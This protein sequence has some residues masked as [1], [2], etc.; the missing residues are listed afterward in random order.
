MKK[1]LL[2]LALIAMASFLFVGCLGEGTVADTDTDTDTDTDVVEPCVITYEA[3]K[4]FTDTAGIKYVQGGANAVEV[5]FTTAIAADDSVW[6][7]VNDGSETPGDWELLDPKDATRF[8]FK[9]TLT[10]PVDKSGCAPICVE[11]LVGDICCSDTVY[12]ETV[13]VD[14]T[15][16]YV[17]VWVSAVDCGDCDEQAKLVFTSSKTDDCLVTSSC[18][19][20]DCSDVAG[21]TFKLWTEADYADKDCKTPCYEDEGGCPLSFNTGCLPCL[22]FDTDST[23][24]YRADFVLTDNVGNDFKDTWTITLDSDSI[25]KIEGLNDDGQ[26]IKGTPDDDDVVQIYTSD[27]THCVIVE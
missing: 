9:G 12:Y 27:A 14:N 19:G 2:V 17:N 21:W 11:V 20:D 24:V 4:S 22:V 7:R 8:V 13:R 26:T 15:N 25:T 10:F 16:P 5:A 1:L 3:A 23:V 18:C 6:I